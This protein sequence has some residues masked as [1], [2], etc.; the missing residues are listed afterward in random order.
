MPATIE[1]DRIQ[2]YIESLVSA[3]LHAITLDITEK[4]NIIEAKLSTIDSRLTVLEA[5]VINLTSMSHTH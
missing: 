2:S 3:R 5:E 1:E 4:L